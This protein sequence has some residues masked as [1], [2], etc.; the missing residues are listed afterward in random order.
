[1]DRGV[2][3][4]P[5]TVT[6]T[7]RVQFPSV[8]QCHLSTGEKMSGS[9][10]VWGSGRSGKPKSPREKKVAVCPDCGNPIEVYGTEIGR[11]KDYGRDKNGKP[12]KRGAWAWCKKKKWTS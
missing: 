6:Q 12:K 11:H 5:L 3:A 9:E 10:W 4:A 1:M 8:Q 2:M 7:E